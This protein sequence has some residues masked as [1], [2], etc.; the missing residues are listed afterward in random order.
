M[1]PLLDDASVVHD[2]DQIGPL[3][4]QFLHSARER[5]GGSDALRLGPKLID[6]LERYHWPGNVRELKAVIERA[7]ILARGGEI[8]R[9]HL[10]FAPAAGDSPPQAAPAPP[11]EPSWSP[12]EADERQRIIDALEACAGNQTRA[13]KYLGV[14]RATLVNKLGLYRIPRPRK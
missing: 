12:Q 3:A 8:G 13:A 7:V 14:S 10:M 6:E 9:R 11:R 2:E 5:S 1:R 4:L